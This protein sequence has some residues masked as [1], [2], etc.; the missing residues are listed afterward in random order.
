MAQN[1][2]RKP[3][4]MKM[5][6]YLVLFTPRRNDGLASTINHMKVVDAWSTTG[7]IAYSRKLAVD[8]RAAVINKKF[9]SP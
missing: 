9:P 1:F 2:K 5:R 6:H 4:N 7:D 3:P 8:R